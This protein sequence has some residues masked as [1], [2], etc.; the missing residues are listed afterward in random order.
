MPAEQATVLETRS[1]GSELMMAFPHPLDQLSVAESD[2]AR[3]VVLTAR[4]GSV[5]LIFRSIALAEPPKDELI[6]F[7]ELEH[8]GRVTLQTPRP[9]RMAKVSYDI[10]RDDRSHGY[11]E[12]LVDVQSATEVSQRI[13]DEVHQAALTTY[14]APWLA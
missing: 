8:A 14:V 13:V 11:T 7:L 9:A 1:D 5:A 2:A 10:V 4:G 3:Q 12:S 6:K